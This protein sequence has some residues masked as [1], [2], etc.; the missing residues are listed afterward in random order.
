VN[1][2]N[3]IKD[4]G[5]ANPEAWWKVAKECDYATFFHTP[6]WHRLAVQTYPR[7]QDASI[8]VEL[9]TGV[10]AI[11]PL[12]ETLPSVKGLFRNFISTF[13]GCYGGLIADGPVTPMERQQ[14]YKTLLSR[15]RCGQLQISGNPLVGGNEG[16]DHFDASKDFTH[17]LTLDGGYDGIFRNFS[18]GHRSAVAKG[19]RMGVKTRVAL[20]LDDYHA[21][22]RAY[23]DSLRRWGDTATSRYPQQL[24]DNGYRLS[25]EFPKNVKLWLA[26]IEGKVIAGAWVFYWNLHAGHW[27]GATYEEFFAYK[28]A[29]VLQ[30]DIIKNACERGYRYY[31]F[32][33]SG[34]HEGVARFK[35]SFGADQR[36]MRRWSYRN[37]KLQMLLKVRK[38]FE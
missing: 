17:L 5:K 31:D 6:L 29:N 37:P 14:V 18:K 27:H 23:E 22:Y 19:R 9:E 13:A 36:S 15:Y 3:Y 20:T 34:G 10:G 35:K 2:L 28:P 16:L 1:K 24:F 26:E 30:A 33:S 21:Y 11:L 32:L 8:M 4:I 25:Q 12:L 7:Y 38:I